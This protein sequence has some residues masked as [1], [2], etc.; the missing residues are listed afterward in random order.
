MEDYDDNQTADGIGGEDVQIRD[1]GRIQDD[2]PFVLEP[3]VTRSKG[4]CKSR[5]KGDVEE[6]A[7]GGN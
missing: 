3:D 2:E 7:Q 1:D 4:L 5:G 6:R